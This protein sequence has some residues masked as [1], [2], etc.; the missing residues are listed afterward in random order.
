MA[1]LAPTQNPAEFSDFIKNLQL[2]AKRMMPT[3]IGSYVVLQV[4]SLLFQ[5]PAWFINWGSQAAL[6]MGQSWVA[7]ASIPLSCC[8]AL[9]QWVPII[10]I[11]GWLTGLYRVMRHQL[12]HPD[13]PLSVGGAL[14]L[15]RQ[16][17]GWVIL[18]N[19]IIGLI[20]AVGCCVFVIPGFIAMFF[21]MPAIYLVAATDDDIPEAITRSIS[22]ALGN[23]LIMLAWMGTALIIG[24]LFALFYMCMGTGI[25]LS[26]VPLQGLFPGSGT[27]GSAFLSPFCLGLTGLV[28]S[29][30]M[31]IIGGAVFATMELADSQVPVVE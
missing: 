21:F 3:V 19:F 15:A 24:I 10:I 13:E 20:I 4:A 26:T 8:V 2:L 17:I 23:P 1:E 5:S 30:P 27:L 12:I 16:R 28:L 25:S 9:F 6:E 14:T 18:M 31:F 29:F 7:L 11:G 22:L